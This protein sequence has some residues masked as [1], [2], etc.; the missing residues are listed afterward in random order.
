MGE[1]NVCF[2]ITLWG[3]WAVLSLRRGAGRHCSWWN[4]EKM[5]GW[6]S[7]SE[8]SQCAASEKWAYRKHKVSSLL[9]GPYWEYRGLQ[10]SKRRSVFT[11]HRAGYSNKLIASPSARLEAT[12]H[13]RFPGYRK[14][15]GCTSAKL[16]S[17]PMGLHSSVKEGTCL[18]LLFFLF[19][20]LSSVSR[21]AACK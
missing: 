19:W 10:V 16:P 9:S 1:D 18:V 6:R 14:H 7:C 3:V 5:P 21:E 8:S 11:A 13:A 20:S 2:N 17:I 4:Q 15:Q 12:D